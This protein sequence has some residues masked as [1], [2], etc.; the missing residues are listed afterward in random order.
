MA[1][2]SV[3]E[4]QRRTGSWRRAGN[5]DL[6]GFRL[7]LCLRWEPLSQSDISD[8]TVKGSCLLLLGNGR[9]AGTSR[10]TD[11]RLLVIQPRSDSGSNWEAV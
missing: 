6:C 3:K 9:W 5:R 4:A 7:L 1:Q 11:R 8:S 10:E 2:G